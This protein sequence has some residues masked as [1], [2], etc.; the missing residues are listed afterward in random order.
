M[1]NRFSWD[2]VLTAVEH[3]HDRVCLLEGQDKP[4]AEQV[5]DAEQIKRRLSETVRDLVMEEYSSKF[6]IEETVVYGSI[7][8]NLR[9]RI[10]GTNYFIL[11]EAPKEENEICTFTAFYKESPR[12]P[13]SRGLV[14]N[15]ETWEKMSKS[16]NA[17]S[18]GIRVW[19]T[20]VVPL[21]LNEF[22]FDEV[23]KGEYRM[24]IGHDI[25]LTACAGM[26]GFVCVLYRDVPVTEKGRNAD[27]MRLFNKKKKLDLIYITKLDKLVPTIEA[28][29][30]DPMCTPTP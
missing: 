5:K 22:T 6:V 24:I 17:I 15:F 12:S 9:F 7:T 14:T 3:L 16:I 25:V 18:I 19:E 8:V 1:S 27:D 23:N 10:P 4:F 11:I 28:L 26:C 20:K 21:L 13:A 2:A 29:L 30:S